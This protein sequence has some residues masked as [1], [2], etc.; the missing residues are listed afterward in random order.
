MQHCSSSLLVLLPQN[1]FLQ[2]LIY[3]HVCAQYVQSFATQW[4]IAHQTRKS[5]EYSRQEYW[6]GWVSFHPNP[7]IK[8]ASPALAGGFF[9]TEPPGK[10]NWILNIQHYQVLWLCIQLIVELKLVQIRYFS[11]Q[12]FCITWLF[13]NWTLK[14]YWL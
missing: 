8:P 4:T 12:I 1:L 11:Y 6:S 5:M 14:D 9:A 13:N 10:S 2:I 7:R 3:V